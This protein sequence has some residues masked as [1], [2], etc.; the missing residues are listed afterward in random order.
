MS[1]RTVDF[2]LHLW[3]NTAVPVFLERF[4]LP[5]FAAAVF[6]TAYTNPMGFDTTQRVTGSL[7]LVL[8][9]YFVAH[10]AYK[11][12]HPPIPPEDN[13]FSVEI[14]SDLLVGGQQLGNNPYFWVFTEPDSIS[15]I[16]AVLALQVTNLQAVPTA[17]SEFSVELEANGSW[18]LLSYVS[19]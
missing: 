10:T 17:V 7:A 12:A 19:F 13:L 14:Y 9:A 15:P 4:V 16:D 3:H 2:G 5:L 1:S 8:A 11:E 6:A 18:T